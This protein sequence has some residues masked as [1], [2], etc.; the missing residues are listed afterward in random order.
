MVIVIELDVYQWRMGRCKAAGGR[1]SNCC[2]LAVMGNTTTLPRKLTQTAAIKVS[3]NN[4]KSCTLTHRY[5]TSMPPSSIVST[6]SHT[7][8]FLSTCHTVYSKFLF[9]LQNTHN[10]VTQ[11]YILL[12]YTSFLDAFHSFLKFSVII[13]HSNLLLRDL[14]VCG[15]ETI[16]HFLNVLELIE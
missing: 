4:L 14:S 2:E 5:S 3:T 1:R 15:P 10:F 9:Q 13:C 11:N 6:V 16:R 12:D 7:L 8:H